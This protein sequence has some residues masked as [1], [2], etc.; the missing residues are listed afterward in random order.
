MICLCIEITTLMFDCYCW[1]RYAPQSAFGVTQPASYFYFQ[2]LFKN[3]DFS[4]IYFT[5]KRA[6]AK[7][8]KQIAIGINMIVAIK[9]SHP[10]FPC[11]FA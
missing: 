5:C 1:F 2:I 3:S 4:K 11:A 7:P 6:N 8:I 10:D 9:K